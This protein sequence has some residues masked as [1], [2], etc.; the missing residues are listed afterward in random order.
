MLT[1]S[2]KLKSR[3]E[4]NIYYIKSLPLG[5]VYPDVRMPCYET[6]LSGRLRGVKASRSPHPSTKV[7]LQRKLRIFMRPLCRRTTACAMKHRLP[8]CCITTYVSDAPVAFLELI[9]T[10][11]AVASSTVLQHSFYYK[12]AVLLQV[13]MSCILS[14]LSV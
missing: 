6:R 9:K 4:E 7:T 11:H 10:M 2:E 12:G 3:Q 5:A 14:E 13:K 8:C 1:V